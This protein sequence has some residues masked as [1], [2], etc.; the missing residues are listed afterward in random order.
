MRQTFEHLRQTLNNLHCSG[1]DLSTYDLT[2]V[3]ENEEVFAAKLAFAADNDV[4]D[5]HHPV[6]M[7]EHLNTPEYE[8]L[9][10]KKE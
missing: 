4:L 3:Q 6:L 5:K 10:S 2:I 7:P 9:E 1:F 8:A